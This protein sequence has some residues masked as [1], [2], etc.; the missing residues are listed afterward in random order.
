MNEAAQTG[1][2]GID[3]FTGQLQSGTAVPGLDAGSLLGN[4]SMTV[5]IV[6]I[7]AGLVGS[8]CFGSA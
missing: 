3:A 5:I 6:C 4:M 2:N 1:M 8:C 7:V